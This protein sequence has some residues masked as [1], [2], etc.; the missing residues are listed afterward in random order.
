MS[1]PTLVIGN[2]NYSSW[3]LRPWVLLRHN[4]IPF[5]EK[6]IAL[7]TPSTDTE[8]APYGSDAKV[9]ILK[10]GD[11]IVWDSLAIL[12]YISETWLCGAGW[13]EEPG[14]R[15]VARSVSAEMHSSFVNVRSEFPMNCRKHFFNVKPSAA[16]AAEIGRIQGLWDDCRQRFGQAG[17]WLFGRYTIADAMFAPVVLRFHGYNIGLEGPSADYMAMVLQQPAII[18]WIEAGKQE[19][20]IIAE[21]EI[22]GD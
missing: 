17:P 2:K 10:H 3:S 5:E 9:P 18:E 7:F 21:D 22:D 15:A 16:A 20:E 11:L 4:D 13:P 14:A 1:M 8:L 19:T 6:R 12:E